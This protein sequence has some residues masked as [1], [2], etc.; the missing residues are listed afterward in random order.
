[1]AAGTVPHLT[2][3]RRAGGFGGPGDAAGG[4]VGRD[5]TSRRLRCDGRAIGGL[6]CH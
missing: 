1:V 6:E 4:R 2:P 3:S 5:R